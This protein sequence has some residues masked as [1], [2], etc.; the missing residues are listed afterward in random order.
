MS[1]LFNPADQN[2]PLILADQGFDVWMGNTR[3]TRFSRR[4]KYL[5]PNQPVRF[6]QPL[7]NQL[8][9]FLLNQLIMYVS[10]F[11]KETEINRCHVVR[12]LSG[13]GRGTSL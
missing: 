11:C 3:G 10:S 9:M 7:L 12:R 8:I 5:S 4:H 6:S 1:W 2:L 13:T